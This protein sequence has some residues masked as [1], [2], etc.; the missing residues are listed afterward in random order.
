LKNCLHYVGVQMSIKSIG[1]ALVSMVLA[2]APAKAEFLIS[3]QEVGADVVATG[4]G[5]IDTRGLTASSSATIGEYEVIQASAALI[6]F[7]L[8]VDD[9]DNHVFH[10]T[11]YSG[12]SGP[13]SFGPG[14]GI[15]KPGDT[16]S[17]APFVLTGKDGT[18]DLPVNYASDTF[19]TDMDIWHNRTFRSLGL[20]AGTYTYTF[21]SGANA[22]SIVVQIGAVPEPS[23]WAMMIL[24]FAGIGFLAYRRRSAGLRLAC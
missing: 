20:A 7:G 8:L 5:S 21:G 12:V 1:I 22:D 23:A 4:N 10:F 11:A 18:I 17:G 24:G 9:P 14:I 19:F 2:L 16:S 3:I 6:G 13:T 15:T